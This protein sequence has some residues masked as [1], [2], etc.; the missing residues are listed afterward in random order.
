MNVLT[1]LY[2]PDEGEIE[3]AGRLVELDHRATRSTP[4]SGW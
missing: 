3:V 1:G 4:G 2:H